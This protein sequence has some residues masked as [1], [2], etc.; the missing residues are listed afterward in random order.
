MKT[1]FKQKVRILTDCINMGSSIAS[2]A[3][4]DVPGSSKNDLSKPV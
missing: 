1:W 3:A 4:S 2:D